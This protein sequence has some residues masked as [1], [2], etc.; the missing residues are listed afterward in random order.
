MTRRLEHLQ[1]LS[2][3]W[4]FSGFESAEYIPIGPNL[5]LMQLFEELENILLLWLPLAGICLLLVA[6]VVRVVLIILAMLHCCGLSQEKV[7]D[8]DRDSTPIQL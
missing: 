3:P 5:V 6:L 4:L 1:I 7:V 8:A 2:P